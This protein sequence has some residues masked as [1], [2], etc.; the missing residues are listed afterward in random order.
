[1]SFALLSARL[2]RRLLAVLFLFLPLLAWAEQAEPRREATLSY[3]NRPIMVFRTELAGTLPEQ[4]AAR[5][6]RRLEE[7]EARHERQ[8]RTIPVAMGTQQGIGVF[9]GDVLLFTVL[10]EDVNPEE[11]RDVQI[12]AATAKQRLDVAIAAYDAQH[13]PVLLGQSFLRLLL[14]LALMLVASWLLWRLRGWVTRRLQDV[15]ARRLAGRAPWVGYLAQVFERI[16]QIFVGMVLFAFVYLWVTY[17]LAQFPLTHPFS[18]QLGRFL[19]S[20]LEN[21]GRG[22]LGAL[23][24]LVTLAVILLITR[25]LAQSLHAILMLYRKAG[26]SCRACTAKRWGPRA[27]L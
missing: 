27:A 16:V 22:F 6:F 26:F 8:I 13:N 14:A 23:P 5:A 20:L 19:I 24:N 18:E 2:L 21:F 1:M 10:P 11:S 25:A 3:M 9:A 15:V 4:R 7:A 17:A 12:L